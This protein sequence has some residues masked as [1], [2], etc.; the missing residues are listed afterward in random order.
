M[1]IAANV[2]FSVAANAQQ[3]LLG[4][5]V[6]EAAANTSKDKAFKKIQTEIN[7]VYSDL[8]DSYDKLI[9]NVLVLNIDTFTNLLINK[10][11]SNPEK[12]LD[13][14]S[15]KKVEQNWGNTSSKEYI[16]L[17]TRIHRLV[18]V[19]HASILSKQKTRNPIAQLNNEARTIF[20]RTRNIENDVSARILGVAF[21]KSIRQVFGSSA[22]LA[23]DAPELG[24]SDS[25]FIFFSSSFSSIGD[26]IR[27]KVYTPLI[28]YI[29]NRMLG[30][31]LETRSDIK[32]GEIVNL[33]HA[34]LVNELGSYVN[35]PAFAK[36]L[37]TVAKGGSS[38]FN[39]TELSQAAD[40][41]K[42]ESRIIENKI[43]VSKDFGSVTS[44]YGILLSLGVTF[45]NLEDAAINSD[46]GRRYEGPTA[47]AI[48][49]IKTPAQS[50]KTVEKLA[51]KL[52]LAVFRLN[53]LLGRSGKTAVEYLT[54]A[55]VNTLKAR[56]I[57]SVKH[58]SSK[59]T[60]T[61]KTYYTPK[62]T[63]IKDKSVN[64]VPYSIV[65]VDRIVPSLSPTNLIDLQ[66]LINQHLQNVISANMG[67]GNR[68]DVLNYRTGRFASSAKVEY[69]SE[70]RAGMI[71]AFYSYMKNPYATFSGGGQQQYPRSRDPKSL[72]SKSIREIAATQVGNRLRAVNV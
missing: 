37:F 22:V 72:I 58:K 26:S 36:S 16:A 15:S 12:F 13:E 56:P 40:F 41:F 31:E 66:N 33:G 25:T 18:K 53:P 7:R 9:P 71:T 8:R 57:K 10:I 63:S 48:G 3:F 42:K 46:R 59:A 64:K 44:G 11:I 47:R 61:K 39:P 21:G 30:G 45:T 69:I 43:E 38:K 27:Q 49:T 55:L 54:D 35:S 6:E 24:S 60:K 65:N 4:I 62:A 2:P 20:T 23:A 52:Y 1:S 32:I 17:R 34:T 28:A 19:Y 67:D 51:N 50:A 68:R 70:S 29:R 5:A 14:F